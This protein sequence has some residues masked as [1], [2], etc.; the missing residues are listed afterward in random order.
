M[1]RSSRDPQLEGCVSL[2]C[3]EPFSAVRSNLSQWV[4]LIDVVG[5]TISRMSADRVLSGM[6]D[7]GTE[8]QGPTQGRW[9]G[10]SAPQGNLGLRLREQPPSGTLPVP[11]QHEERR[12]LENLSP[13]Q[14][15]SGFH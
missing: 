10:G 4:K 13:A 2:A 6:W 7:T 12:A 11:H 5:A 9:Q 15:E 14:P 8:Y 1:P 3:R